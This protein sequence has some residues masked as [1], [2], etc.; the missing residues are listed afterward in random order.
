MPAAA[1]DTREELRAKIDLALEEADAW[2]D[3]L[4]VHWYAGRYNACLGHLHMGYA[5][6]IDVARMLA[7]LPEVPPMTD[8]EIFDACYRELLKRW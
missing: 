2:R 6:L 8:A 1:G 7:A 3:S 5:V 4:L